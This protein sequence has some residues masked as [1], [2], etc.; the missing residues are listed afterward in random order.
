MAGIAD[1]LAWA[2]VILEDS[3]CREAARAALDFE[4]EIYSEKLGNWPDLIGSSVPIQAMQGLCSGSPGV[5]LALLR[6]REIGFDS[7]ELDEDIE[8]A[9]LSCMTKNPLYRDHLC[10]GNSSTVDFLLSVPGCHEQAGRLLAFM[11]RRKDSEGSYHFMPPIYRQVPRLD[12]F[13]GAAGIGYEML[14]Y[15]GVCGLEHIIF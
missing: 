9:K 3:R 1:A 5:G 7:P 8:R 10:C 6:C 2:S 15:A 12:L 11:K 14:R 13:F 4:H